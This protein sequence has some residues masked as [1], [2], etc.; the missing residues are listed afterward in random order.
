[1][2]NKENGFTL[3]EL[4]V[5]VAIIGLLTS[6]VISSL[7]AAKQKGGDTA[8]VQALLEVR[9]A[10][11]LYFTDNGSFPIGDQTALP[12]YLVNGAKKYIA[13]INPN[14]KYQ[15]TN[16]NNSI[17]AS[18]CQSYHLGIALAA[19]NNKVLSSDKDVNVGFDGTKDDCVSL[20]ASIPDKCYDITP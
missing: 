4:I 2:K 16:A 9:S 18:N 6:I 15:S 11:Q 10:L 7:G 8:K 13:S 17:C 1:M 19:S 12:G 20:P 3:I 14:I 5:V